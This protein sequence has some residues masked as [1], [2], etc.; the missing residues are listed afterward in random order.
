LG[1]RPLG[2]SFGTDLYAFVK[3]ISMKPKKG[4]KGKGFLEFKVKYPDYWRKLQSDS[5]LTPDDKRKF[6]KHLGAHLK[7][8]LE[9]HAA[10]FFN[11]HKLIGRTV[12]L[13][14]GEVIG[15]VHAKSALIRRLCE[16]CGLTIKHAQR[17]IGHWVSLD[18]KDLQSEIKDVLGE[19]TITLHLMWSYRNDKKPRDPF[20]EIEIRDLPCRLGLR[21]FGSDHY[22]FGHKLS[23]GEKAYIPT[24]FDA[25]LYE[26]WEPGGV[27]KPHDACNT[28]YPTGLPEVVHN[29]NKF[30]N[31]STRL[32]EVPK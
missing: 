20:F 15:S 18:F 30:Q 12:L 26:Q 31:I 9:D 24:S 1:S 25:G 19:E 5:S 28:K 23:A 17:K 7:G 6:G 11:S 10:L 13:T 21:S 3:E 27:T 16:C 4:I 29:P 2:L 14:L 32:F 8:T 22:A